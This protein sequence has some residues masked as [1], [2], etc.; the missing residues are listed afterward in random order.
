MIKRHFI[1]IQLLYGLLIASSSCAVQKD[2]KHFINSKHLIDLNGNKTNIHQNIRSENN[3]KPF[4]LI[5]LA[6]ECPISQKY[7]P[8]LRGMQ[9]Q[10]PD[11]KFIVVFTKWD[12]TEA[13]KGYLNEYPLTI[14]KY[15]I[16]VLKDK[17]NGLINEINAKITPEAFLFNKDGVL[18]Y[19]G[20][21]DNWFYALGKYRPE[22]SENYL[23]DAIDSV[24][25]N[26]PIKIKQT[27]AIGCIIEK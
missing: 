6:A 21:I 13:I 10:F 16:T 1:K 26:E 7:A 23:K 20:A 22:A 12:K 17:K 3:E 18:K 19:R 5:F 24:F 11:V 15:P 2:A 14:T 8:I 25:K 27:D 9:E 4:A